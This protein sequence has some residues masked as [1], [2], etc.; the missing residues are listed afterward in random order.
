MNSSMLVTEVV[1]LAIMVAVALAPSLCSYLWR[2][3]R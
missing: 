3:E 2:K 1:A